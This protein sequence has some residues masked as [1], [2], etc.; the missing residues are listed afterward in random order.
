MFNKAIIGIDLGGTKLRIGR[1]EAGNITKKYS[2]N[3]SSQAGEDIIVGEMI[4][5]IEQVF[6]NDIAGIGIGVPSLVDV[7]EGIVYNVPNIPS[8]EKVY[9][10]AIVE[11]NFN[12]PVYINNDANCFAV[13]EKYFGKGKPFKNMVGLTLGTGMGAGIIINNSL[14]SGNNCG[15]GE[16]GSILYKDHIFEYYCSGQFFRD[17]FGIEG[18]VLSAKAEQGDNES[19][20]IYEQYGVHLGN[21]INSI[22]FAL[23]PQAIILGGSI[24]QSYPYFKKTMWEQINTFP[25][26]HA[27]QDLFIDRTEQPHIALLGAAAL[28][29]N[30]ENDQQKSV[31]DS[32]VITVANSN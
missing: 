11:E 19:L 31:A 29:L 30:A 28:F 27:L 3:I 22:L 12:K 10:K 16:F 5:A 1:I 6:D 32:K 23:D 26:K 2:I 4:H 25:Y 13:G 21:A 24:S 14:Y 9:L 20:K 15:A 17:E 18:H 7:E 8:W